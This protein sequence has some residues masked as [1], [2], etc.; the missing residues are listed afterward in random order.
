MCADALHFAAEG[1][2]RLVSLPGVVRSARSLCTL[3][4]AAA[5]GLLN[6][7]AASLRPA[8]AALAGF[9]DLRRSDG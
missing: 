4:V 3:G 2:E 5:A 9:F 1:V 8:R 7:I 6:T